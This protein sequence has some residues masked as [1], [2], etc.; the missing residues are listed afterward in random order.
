V[1]GDVLSWTGKSQAPV[2][3]FARPPG[4]E[5]SECDSLVITVVFTTTSATLAALEHAA[6]LSAEL[7]AGIRILVPL[8]VPYP[9]PL[10]RPD[11]QPGFKVT[12]LRAL[13][14]RTAVSKWIDVRLCRDPV[15][16]VVRSLRPGSIVVL[17]VRKRWFG[18]RQRRLANRISQ[19]GH[20]VIYVPKKLWRRPR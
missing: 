18:R 7:G 3:A 13:W 6:R 1:R 8:I 15:D 12:Q 9:L 14:A 17:G 19:A 11:S 2:S 10:D 20:E 5:N 16:C 4:F